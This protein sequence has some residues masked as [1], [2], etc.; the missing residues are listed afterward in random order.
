MKILL[1]I[2][3]L[4]L[5][6]NLFAGSICNEGDI[7]FVNIN[8]DAPK[9]F[10]F[11]STIDLDAGSKLFFTDDAWL[12]SI[13]AFRGGE[14]IL[15]FTASSLIKK[16]SIISY[17]DENSDFSKNGSFSLS[18]SGDNIIVYQV[19][20]ND[21]TFINGIGFGKKQ[22]WMFNSSSATSTSDIPCNNY[23]KINVLQLGTNDNY[24]L[25]DSLFTINSIDDLKT[26]LMKSANFIGNN[27][28]GTVLP[29]KEFK[30]SNTLSNSDY[31]F[32]KLL[33]SF[34]CSSVY[35]EELEFDTDSV[36]IF[37]DSM[38]TIRY[39]ENDIINQTCNVYV[40]HKEL[41]L[42]A[43]VKISIDSIPS[44]SIE[45][46]TDNVLFCNSTCTNIEWYEKESDMKVSSGQ[47][48]ITNQSGK[49]YVKLESDNGCIFESDDIEVSLK[50]ENSVFIKNVFKDELDVIEIFKVNGIFE[51][52]YNYLT[53][54]E[55]NKILDS[56][57]YLL[58]ITNNNVTKSQIHFI[59]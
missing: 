42:T 7:L 19:I 53:L 36:E 55:L 43:A 22:N 30:F 23:N 45:K 56:G 5:C 4:F 9:G 2:I 44:L 35:I 59:P 18:T 37:K 24:I 16:G 34:F 39:L 58:K 6:V 50:D 10:S 12:D 29:N 11:V 20:N 33:N 15:T 17:S 52:K 40:K 51:V 57:I 25:T 31:I 32:P 46:I 21:T 54:E 14:G 41:S 13:N 3:K 27:D 28:A 26:I 48:F 47:H 8:S 49:Y 38:M 1:F